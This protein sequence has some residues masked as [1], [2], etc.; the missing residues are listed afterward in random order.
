LNF[1]T[2]GGDSFRNHFKRFDFIGKSLKKKMLG[3]EGKGKGLSKKIRG[4]E[5][6]FYRMG[7][8]NSFAKVFYKPLELNLVKPIERANRFYEK[9]L[10][11]LGALKSKSL[12]NYKILNSFLVYAMSNTALYRQMLKRSKKK[13]TKGLKFLRNLKTG[14][15]FWGR[16][17]KVVEKLYANIRLYRKNLSVDKKMRHLINL[18]RLKSPRSPSGQGYQK[19]VGGL[20][21]SRLHV[22]K[23]KLELKTFG[24][25]RG[26]LIALKK[27]SKLN[28]FQITR[29]MK[30][31]KKAAKI[32]ALKFLYSQMKK[33]TQFK[34]RKK[35]RALV[36]QRLWSLKQSTRKK[37]FKLR[38][39][40]VKIKLKLLKIRKIFLLFI[41]QNLKNKFWLSFS[42]LSKNDSFTEDMLIFLKKYF[43]LKKFILKSEKAT[44]KSIRSPY[45]AHKKLN[46]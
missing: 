18:Y 4:M 29:L 12:R 20:N 40:I 17:S 19:S 2:A 28:F 15:Y 21:L 37:R 22:S 32:L 9:K 35:R 14:L 5:Q 6:E 16:K 11:R 24:A 27:K 41:I 36:K 45:G 13:R 31:K 3:L 30:R 34:N 10:R 43:F 7:A 33:K 39:L 38:D 25:F 26:K 42:I 44:Y 23:N 1:L 8:Y 46:L